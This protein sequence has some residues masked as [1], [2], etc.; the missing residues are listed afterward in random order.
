MWLD[1]SANATNVSSL[2]LDNQLLVAYEVKQAN[3]KNSIKIST[4]GL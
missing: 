2:N 1:D 3:K 4:V